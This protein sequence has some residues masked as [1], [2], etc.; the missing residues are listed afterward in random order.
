[1]EERTFCN[2]TT[3]FALDPVT[4]GDGIE[5]VAAVTAEYESSDG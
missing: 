1:M 3:H 5:E 2:G 4:S